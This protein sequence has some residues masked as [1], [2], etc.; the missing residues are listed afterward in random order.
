M[1]VM[2]DQARQ[3]FLD[4]VV[5][6]VKL[7]S[8]AVLTVVLQF[9][10]ILAGFTLLTVAA[11]LVAV[12]FGVAIAGLSCFVFEQGVSRRWLSRS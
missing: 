1:S 11:W 6:P 12:P 8:R 10:L 4:A 7:P 3:S 5:R 9:T 2:S